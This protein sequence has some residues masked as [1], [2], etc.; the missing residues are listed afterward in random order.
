MSLV[1][2]ASVLVAA[3]AD[4]G[5]EGRWAEAV[6]AEGDLVAPHLVLVETASILRRMDLAGDLA[7]VE[8]S[9]AH[10]DLLR[11]P[12]TLM[13][14]APFAERAWELR[15]NITSYDAWYVAMAE[16]FTLPMATLDRK[17]ARATGPACRFLVPPGRD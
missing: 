4:S 13:P 3:L 12:I 10:R 8:A 14:F 5:E 17:L 11:L 9:L 7:P 1:V 16:A 2:D 15:S 6:L